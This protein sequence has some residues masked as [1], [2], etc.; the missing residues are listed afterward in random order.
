MVKGKIVPMPKRISLPIG[1]RFGRLTIIADSYIALAAT[2]RAHSVHICQCS[3]GQ[4]R[5][6]ATGHLKDGH[7]LSCGCLSSER[8]KAQMHAKHEQYE[9]LHTPKEGSVFGR[10]T[11]AGPRTTD[12]TGR[13]LI[14][15]VCTCGVS[16]DIRLSH[17]LRGKIKSC[18]CLRRESTFHRTE[19][20][21][22]REGP[23]PGAQF[24][25]W[26]ILAEPTSERVP[27]RC[28]CGTE[29]VV[30]L[31]SVT[32]GRSKSCGCLNREVSRKV[33][34]RGNDLLGL[35]PKREDPL[36]GIWASMK[37]RCCNPKHT[38]YANYGGRG[39]RICSD[40]F[41]YYPVFREWAMKNGF[42]PGLTIDRIDNDGNYEP[43][44]C[45]WIS[46]A[47]NSRKAHYARVQSGTYVNPRHR[48]L[49]K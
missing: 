35:P 40:W 47:A 3:C 14:A 2:P 23:P 46:R 11:V 43:S 48:S 8:A 32:S 25:R 28:S 16:K 36:Y 37:Q 31:R 30:L 18:G 10:L 38:H 42:Q 20:L 27:C 4:I 49:S 22:T 12:A 34:R 29:R 6:V 5:H 13:S 24:N 15:C 26:T 9:P 21:P 1:T 45:Q 41:Q 19:G 39:I 7:T 44:N 17:M 33:N